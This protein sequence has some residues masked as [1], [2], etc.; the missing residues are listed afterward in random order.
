M[1]IQQAI[2]T[3]R[4]A[5]QWSGEPV[6]DTAVD[7]AL[8]AAHQAPCH[9]YTWPWRFTVIGPGTKAA[10]VD[11]A[12]DLKLSVGA[13]AERVDKQLAVKFTQAAGAVA[14]SQVL[15]DDEFTRREDY[16]AT[17]CAIQNFVLSLHGHGIHAKWSTGGVTRHPRTY[18]LLGVDPGVEEIVG[19]V[20]YGVPLREPKPIERPP[21]A[22][23]IRRLP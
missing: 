1:D 20:W 3:R 18:A 15:A 5:H 8:A 16:A 13:P 21:L 7:A 17:A 12:R 19:F 22:E 9:K 6:D 11:I 23:H 4:T 14:V 10:F 2:M